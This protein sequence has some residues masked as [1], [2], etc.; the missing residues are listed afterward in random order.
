M[1]RKITLM[2]PDAPVPAVAGGQGLRELSRSG[3]RFGTLDNG[4]G[5][6]DHLL[7]MVA[8]AVKAEVAVKSV[9]VVRKSRPSEP[10]PP[11]ILDHLA[12]EADCVVGAMA[13]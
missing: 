2:V 7:R 9:T 8:D 12:R 13:D 1:T 6:A 4:K 11:E 5:N 10:A 3:I